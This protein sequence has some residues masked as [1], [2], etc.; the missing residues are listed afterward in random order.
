MKPGVYSPEFYFLKAF[1]ETGFVT[2]SKS[3]TISTDTP[4]L[5]K[6][7]RQTNS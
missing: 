4:A 2:V 5:W 3:K 6:P 7:I 1:V